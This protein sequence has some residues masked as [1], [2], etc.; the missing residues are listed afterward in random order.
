M[1]EQEQNKLL[2]DRLSVLRVR[3]LELLSGCDELLIPTP[4]MGA[5]MCALKKE[6][7]LSGSLL[8]SAPPQPAAPAP[9]QPAAPA[10][11]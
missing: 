4:D 11:S 1:T 5:A 8:D 6:I 2:R 3:A 9:P 7:V 10:T